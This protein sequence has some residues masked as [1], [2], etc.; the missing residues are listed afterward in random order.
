MQEAPK[1]VAHMPEQHTDMSHMHINR[2]DDDDDEDDEDYYT[3]PLE[4][5]KQRPVVAGPKIGRNDLCPCGSGQK[6]K[7]CHGK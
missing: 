4:Q 5:P 3:D 7:K 1:E 2:A 6:F